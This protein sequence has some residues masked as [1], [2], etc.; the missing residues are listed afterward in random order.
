MHVGRF[1]VL[2]SSE[3]GQRAMKALGLSST[4]DWDAQMNFVR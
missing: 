4:K 1:S 3:K 2:K